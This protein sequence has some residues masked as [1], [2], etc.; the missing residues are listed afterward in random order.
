MADR[1]FIAIPLP[2][3]IKENI[4]KTIDFPDNFKITKKDN[5]HITVLFLGDT[6]ASKHGIIIN[7]LNN[8][9]KNHA[10]FYLEISKFG[11]FPQRGYPRIIYL[12]GII[13]L[14]K[15]KKLADDIREK[16]REIGFTDDKHFEY[17]VTVARQK[18][19]KNNEIKLPEIIVSHNFKVESVVLYKSELKPEGP[20]YT[21]IWSSRL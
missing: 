21:Q 6:E 16:F 17:H 13:G 19:Y 8:V 9:L 4:I 14:D 2:E 15:L 11:Q 12:T 1:L 3:N 7:T 18:Y 10:P 20:I 5:L